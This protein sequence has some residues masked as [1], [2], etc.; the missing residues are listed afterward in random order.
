M[1][2]GKKILIVEDNKI[3]LQLFIDI[4]SYF[5]YEIQSSLQSDFIINSVKDN[6][7]DLILM[8]IQ[9][10]GVSGFDLIKEIRAIN[11]EIPVI[12]ITAFSTEEKDRE[13]IL[14]M[15]FNELIAKPTSI[16]KLKTAVENCLLQESV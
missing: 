8:D 1:I 11:K 13:N 7:I 12:A 3:N 10:C 2:S 5:D 15:G 16:Q 14:N 4:L 9:L 6:Q